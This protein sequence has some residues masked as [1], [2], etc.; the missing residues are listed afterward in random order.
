MENSLYVMQLIKTKEYKRLNME[1]VKKHVE[2]LREL[3]EAGKIELCGPYKGFPGVAG[4]FVFR[5][6]SLAEAKELCKQ[7]PLVQ[8]G[9]ATFTVHE[10][11]VA[12]KENNYLL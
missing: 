6:E 3:D 7:E 10:L 11:Q 4:M 8:G 12:N 9:Y 2:N 1:W 5:V